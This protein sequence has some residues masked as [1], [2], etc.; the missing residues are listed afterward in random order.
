MPEFQIVSDFKPTGDQPEAV[1]RLVKGLSNQL[2][3][4][5]LI[6]VT[7]SGKTFTAIL[8]L[9]KWLNTSGTVLVLVPSALLLDQ[10]YEEIKSSSGSTSISPF[11][12]I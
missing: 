3:Q 5:S 10:W 12:T 1:D 6:G 9:N 2:S 11:D 4:Q 8:A 7:G